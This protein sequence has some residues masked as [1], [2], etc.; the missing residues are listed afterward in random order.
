MSF[1]ILGLLVLFLASMILSVNNI[2]PREYGLV[3]RRFGGSL[4]NNVVAF[5]HEAG[6]QA[7]LLM[8]GQF[9]F[10]WWFSY[11]VIKLPWPSVPANQI[12]IV[13]AQVGKALPPGAKSGVYRKAFGLF[14]DI[15]AFVQ[16]GGEIGV[17]RPTLPPGFVGP[18]HPVG[19][20]VLTKDR[21]YGIPVG[22]YAQ[23]GRQLTVSDFGLDPS[24]FDVKRIEPAKDDATG[25]TIDRI[26]VV[27]T[28]DGPPLESGSIACRLGGPTGP[29]G[30]IAE[31]EQK[32]H[33]D[34]LLIEAV[35]GSKNS[36]HNSYQDFQAFIDAGGRIGL[37]HDPLLYGAY[38]LNP[39]L[40]RVQYADM[41]VVEQ[42]EVAVV[43][44]YVGLPGV[45][46][47]DE[48]FSHGI[49]VRPGHMGIWRSVLNTGKYP[50]VPRIYQIERVPTHI[51]TLE[52]S[53]APSEALALDANLS[54]I[55]ARS[56]ESFEF[57]IDL[58]TQVV[59][60]AEEAPMSISMCGTFRNLV[61]EVLQAAA[62]NHFRNKLQA[63]A[64]VEFY[65]DREKVQQQ[66]TEHIREQLATYHA[67]VPG[68]FI[69]DVVPDAKLSEILQARELANQQQATYRKQQDAATARAD[70][71]KAEGRADAMADLAKS[72][73]G[74]QTATNAASARKAQADGDAEYT[75]RTTAAEG[76][77]LAEGLEAQ[78][79]AV[80]EIPAAIINAIKAI[81]T[82]LKVMPDVVVSGEQGIGGILSAAIAQHLNGKNAEH[83]ES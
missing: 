22:D 4:E 57:D 7:D 69:Q 33:D 28:L 56:K 9:R 21:V 83:A 47:S 80:G 81:P 75:K 76:L 15:R 23:H 50:L 45:D 12:G 3:I 44:S 14:T 74:V 82:G 54:T 42:G 67:Q 73:V 62:G 61:D 2:G 64:A 63:T 17:Q 79:Q 72:E 55:H 10:A 29:F 43:K 16:N 58:H 20:L 36:L 25:R 13:I 48:N 38:N 27:T 49:L 1:I 6:Y 46:V 19:F 65:E 66:A 68:V 34:T 40:V 59:V 41:T 24:L 77:G 51:I 53:K 71:R 70:M 78:K 8:P 60:P 39:F 52:W 31:T 26:G 32:S 30:D 18:V 5:E 37:Q 11:K 35:L